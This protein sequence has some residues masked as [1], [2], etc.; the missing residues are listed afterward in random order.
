VD[1]GS[2]DEGAA[3]ARRH[4]DTRFRVITQENSGPGAARN[5]GLSE[6]KGELTAFLDA[7]DE[8]LP[9]YLANGVHNLTTQDIAAFTTGYFAEPGGQSLIQMWRKRGITEGIHRIHRDMSPK[10]VVH[11]LAYMS[12][13]ST[14]SRTDILRRWGGFYTAERCLYGEDAFLWLKVLLNERVGFSLRPLARFHI[15]A[16]ML[17]KNLVGARPIEPFL[18]HPE[19][20]SRSCPAD[21]TEL[22]ARVLAIRAIKTACVLGFWGRW[23]EATNL[24][25]RFK[26][27]RPWTLPYYFP[28]LVTRTPIGGMIGAVA[29]RSGWG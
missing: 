17:S 20:I 21:L 1:D 16:S 23:R 2:T 13:C 24:V 14:I 3:I 6:A 27:P 10:L 5:R 4:S 29:R 9:D 28:S 19:E 25:K 8:W 11:M 15:E 22:L 12:P 26:V 18:I 7:D